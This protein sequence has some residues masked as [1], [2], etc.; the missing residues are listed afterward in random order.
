MPKKKTVVEA[1]PVEKEE[2]Q[3]RKYVCARWPYLRLTKGVR[4]DRG[5]LVANE[6]WVAD[7]VESNEQFNGAIRRVAMELHKKAEPT[8]IEQELEARLRLKEPSIH[9]GPVSTKD[10]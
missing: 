10:I 6:Q 5:F 4:F 9:R 3:P 2:F 1:T 7:M 8:E